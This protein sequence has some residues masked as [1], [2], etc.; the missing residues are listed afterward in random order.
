MGKKGKGDLSATKA[1]AKA[2]KRA[3]QESKAAR[4]ETKKVTKNTKNSTA[5]NGNNNNKNQKNKKGKGKQNAGNGV[6]F[7]EGEDLDALL[8]QFREE[9]EN[10]HK[11]TEEKVGQAPSRRAN[12]TLTACPL[13]TDLWLFGG[14]YFDGDRAMFY[15]DLFRYTP[16]TVAASN[17]ASADDAIVDHG[18]WR[19]Y[20]SPTQPGPRSAHQIAATAA[21]GGQLWLFGGEF[22]GMRMTSFHHYRDLWV[23]HIAT[24]QWERIDTKVRPSARSGHRMAFWKH[25][26]V[27]FGGFQDTGA[28]TTYLGDLW[29]FDTSEYKWHEIKQNDLRKPSSRSGFSLITSTDGVILHGG[30]CKRYV[31]GQR[32]QGVALEDTWLLKM[33]LGEDGDLFINGSIEWQRRRK[34]GYAPGPRSGCTMAVWGNRNMGVLFGGVVDTETDEESL[35]SQCF[36]DLFGYQ[37]AGNGRWIS[38]NLRKP[39]KKGGRRRRKPAAPIVEQN[40][41]SD[42]DEENAQ[43]EDEQSEEEPEDDPDDPQKSVP[44]VRYNTMLAVQRNTLYAYGG[45]HETAERE[46]TMDDFHTLDLS[47]M[48]RFQCLK[49]C[50]IDNLEWN[51]S[52]SESGS[53]DEDEDDSSSS[54]SED[55]EELP[56][57]E[58]YEAEVV[59][60]EDYDPFLQHEEL[61]LDDET[62]AQLKREREEREELRKRTQTFLGVSKQSNRT[63][64]DVLSTPL[65]GES[66]R[67]FYAR[68][69]SYW[70]SVAH[71]QSQGQ[72]RGKEMRRDGFELAEKKYLELKPVLQ[73]IERIQRE[74]GL[75]EEEMKAAAAGK[76]GPGGGTG[77]DSRNRR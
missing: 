63:E 72:S 2:A 26:L 68:S 51:E 54:S 65:P 43:N 73:E 30:Y 53:S 46:Y 37:I 34:I 59:R 19:M 49:A 74:A 69:K 47:K 55:V 10:E 13:G 15:P 57:G 60:E 9:W 36:N 50:P 58:E 18:T 28:R 39:K 7:D 23:F 62:L 52:A 35:E 40:N 22:A 56:E 25:F 8:K 70:A 41:N 67:D 27:L 31:K 3:K 66:L 21:N 48:D 4:A 45:I 20:A 75:D 77:V 71:E 5:T 38:L 11:T 12:A 24:K 76:S 1:A 17:V 29:I 14:E 6:V 44:I 61:S 42:D 33:T 64:E 32:T 16:A